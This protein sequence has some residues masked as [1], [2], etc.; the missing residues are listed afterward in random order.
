MTSI[1]SR[2]LAVLT[3]LALVAGAVGFSSLASAATGG[4]TVVLAST[5][6]STTTSAS[7]PITVT[8]SEGV[9]G[10]ATTSIATTNASVSGLTGTGAN[11]SF[12][13]I[14]TA[15]G[16]V[17]VQVN[18]DSATASTTPFAGNQVSNLLTFTPAVT[19][20]PVIS[21]ITVATGT[22]TTDIMWN[23]SVPATGLVRYGSTSAYDA[24]STPDTALGTSHIAFLGGLLPSTM[25]HFAVVS[26]NASG[27]AMSS[28]QAFTTNAVTSTT[29]ASSTALA[30]TG[31]DAINTTASADGSFTSGWKWVIH[32]TVPSNETSFQMKF[33]DFSAS[34]SSSTIPIANNLRY[35]SAQSSNAS[36]TASAIVETGNGYGGAL[37]LT[38][39]T[40]TTT[41]GRQIDITIETAIPAG[42]SNGSYSTTF[43]ALSQ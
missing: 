19:T 5:S 34:G 41:A 25:Y 1:T 43:G 15:S 23:T 18:A 30:V 12:N 7:I 36:T 32:F 37:L 38:G 29:T 26:T 27:T 33:A 4:P 20:L 22:D 35:S 16:T 31:V 21:G 13:L 40:S 3:S 2:T 6:A 28:D 24:S 11:Y 39:D 8:F 42:T 14:P 17:T 9:T 10:F